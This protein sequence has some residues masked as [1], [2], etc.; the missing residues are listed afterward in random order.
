[1]RFWTIFTRPSP[2]DRAVTDGRGEEDPEIVEA[3]DRLLAPFAPWLPEDEPPS[4]TD[5][6]P[7]RAP[8]AVADAGHEPRRVV[9]RFTLPP[10]AIVAATAA[11]VMVVFAAPASPLRPYVVLVFTLVCPGIALVRLLA[12]ADPL[13]E[14]ATGIGLSI[15]IELLASTTMLYAHAWSPH[16]LFVALVFL[17]LG[18]ASVEM[19]G[20]ENRPR[21]AL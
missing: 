5:R 13:I 16:A 2:K 10:A 11:A 15:T 14:L 21:S 1:M 8:A 3:L 7:V 12:I 19:A 18:A 4:P 20:F 17:T 6:Q 9:F